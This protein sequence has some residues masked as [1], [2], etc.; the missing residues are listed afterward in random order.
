MVI[1]RSTAASDRVQNFTSYFPAFH[2]IPCCPLPCT[3]PPYQVS[4]LGPRRPRTLGRFCSFTR[5]AEF[6]IS[7]PFSR[8]Q[9][10]TGQSISKHLSA[11]P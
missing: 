1:S 9:C 7:V 5:L 11:P 2:R 10:A 3:R 8:A 4:C 6:I